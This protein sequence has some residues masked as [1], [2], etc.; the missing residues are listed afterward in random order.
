MVANSAQRVAPACTDAAAQLKA[1]SEQLAS[2]SG[3]LST[4]LAEW[5]SCCRELVKQLRAA[6][7]LNSSSNSSKD[8]VASCLQMATRLVECGSAVEAHRL[9]DRGATRRFLSSNSIAI[10]LTAVMA[11]A[12]QDMQLPLAA[13]PA[14]GFDCI[15]DVRWYRG[16]DRELSHVSI[17]VAEIKASSAGEVKAGHG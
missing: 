5:D 11:R 4:R 8:G 10:C 7:A 13:N 15:P 16:P 3:D 17:S 12:Q 14:V 1:I 2:S 6:K 9:G